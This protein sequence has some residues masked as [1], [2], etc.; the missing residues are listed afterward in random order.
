M[1]SILSRFHSNDS[2]AHS[3]LSADIENKPI[4]VRVVVKVH[5]VFILC[6]GGEEETI[7]IEK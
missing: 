4:A 7:E 1:G 2:I 5:C 3:A 6:A